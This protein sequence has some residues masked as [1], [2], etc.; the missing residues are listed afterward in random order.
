LQDG[1]FKK[2]VFFLKLKWNIY[3]RLKNKNRF[4]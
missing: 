2:S 4:K 3:S 1:L